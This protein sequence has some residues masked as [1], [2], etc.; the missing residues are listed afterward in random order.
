M[1]KIFIFAIAVA[2]S[3]SANA[4]VFS[5]N[6][7]QILTGLG[8]TD[9]TVAT[10]L[11][12]GAVFADNDVFTL[13]AG[14]ADSYKAV[15]V[16]ANGYNTITFGTDVMD[17]STMGIQGASNPKDDAT[18]NPG[19]TF[20]APVS[21]AYFALTTKASVPETG[22][23]IY[24][25]HKA[26]S[27]KNYT[28]FEE[29]TIAPYTFAMQIDPTKNANAQPTGNVL[30]FTLPAD[31]E[32]YYDTTNGPIN[33]PIQIVNGS[34]EA[35]I[36]SAGN[37]LG[38]IMFKVYPEETFIFNA[39]GSKMSLKGIYYSA[40]PVETV[41]ISGPEVEGVKPADV[42]LIGGGAGINNIAADAHNAN[43]PIYNLAGQR[44]SKDAKGILIQNGKKFIK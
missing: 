36:T 2:A 32:G 12:A 28:V 41:T 19:Q 14:A 27:N 8:A 17:C 21:G 30:S 3:M 35:T 16:D 44:V 34:T 42:T 22:G 13:K 9:P 29:G 10:R 33:W 31:A 37:G 38:V 4:Q 18:Q 43:A 20:K 15:T 23:Y 1:K 11:A 26:S 7:E 5:L 40:T 25:V 24:V 39:C 6:A